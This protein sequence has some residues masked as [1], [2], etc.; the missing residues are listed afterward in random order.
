MYDNE[1]GD[2]AGMR[3]ESDKSSLSLLDLVKRSEITF[4]EEVQEVTDN[5]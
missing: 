2:W 4:A 1:Y 5:E 3:V